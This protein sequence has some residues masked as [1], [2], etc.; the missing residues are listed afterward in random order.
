MIK[1]IINM[2]IAT[3]VA[4]SAMAEGTGTSKDPYTSLPPNVFKLG[5]GEDQKF[6][7]ASGKPGFGEMVRNCTAQFGPATDELNVSKLKAHKNAEKIKAI[8][9]ANMKDPNAVKFEGIYEPHS[10]TVC[11]ATTPH[12]DSK[13]TYVYVKTLLYPKEEPVLVVKERTYKESK[14]IAVVFANGKNSYGGYVGTKPYTIYE[15]GTLESK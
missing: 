11:T 6:I 5:S 14:P 7:K 1:L 13:M 12:L 10:R 2:A 15:N 3:M 9:L 4:T 8:V